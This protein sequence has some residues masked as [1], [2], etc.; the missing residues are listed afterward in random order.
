M[1]WKAARNSLRRFS[2]AG[3]YAG[4]VSVSMA[5]DVHDCRPCRPVDPCSDQ[6]GADHQSCQSDGGDA[7]NPQAD[8]PCGLFN[9]VLA[10][11]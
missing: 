8:E 2:R 7:R 11:W 4:L 10:Q 6:E 9:D 5:R 1:P 3:E